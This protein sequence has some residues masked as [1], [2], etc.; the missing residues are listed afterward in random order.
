MGLWPPYDGPDHVA[1]FHRSRPGVDVWQRP[2]PILP[3]VNRPSVRI[4]PR[5]AHAAGR[6][7][8]G[9][10]AGLVLRCWSGQPDL[11]R[12]PPVP[13]PC[14]SRPWGSVG[15]LYS[16]SSSVLN[17][18]ERPGLFAPIG[19]NVGIR[20][21]ELGMTRTARIACLMPPRGWRTWAARRPDRRWTP[22]PGGPL[23]TLAGLSCG[24][25]DIGRR[26]RADQDSVTIHERRSC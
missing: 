14:P 25:D 11:N 15:V 5:S 12:R 1:G 21:P 20:R 2:R 9:P 8:T 16:C 26:Y 10:K 6:E 22:R 19:I 17:G 18:V 7:E 4:R 3:R 23:A 13:Q 24:A